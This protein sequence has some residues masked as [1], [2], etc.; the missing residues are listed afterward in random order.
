[1]GAAWAR[2]NMC[3]LAFSALYYMVGSNGQTYTQSACVTAQE[4]FCDTNDVS[5][6]E[7]VCLTRHW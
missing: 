1:M 4:R 7:E 2:H 6:F 5:C 3:E